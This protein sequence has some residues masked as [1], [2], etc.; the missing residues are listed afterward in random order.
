M[1]F[2]LITKALKRVSTPE[3]A[4]FYPT[5]FKT[6]P[7]EYGEGDVFIGVSVPDIRAVA[8]KFLDTPYPEI[9]ALL[10]SEIH[11][12]RTCG[13]FILVGNFQRGGEKARH[14]I[15]R[16][17]VKHMKQVN[18]WDLVDLS[19]P[20]IVGG[21]LWESKDFTTLDTWA[22]SQNLWKRRIAI[23]STLYLIRKEHFAPTLR[24]SKLLLSDSQDLIHKAVGWMLREAGKKEFAVV[25]TFVDQHGPDMPRTMLRYAIERFPKE[26][27][28]H[29]LKKTRNSP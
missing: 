25:Q 27:R 5:F 22:R 20:A 6:Q 29:Y 14:Q 28:L 12:H 21:M 15:F 8:K 3:K 24:I 11:E 7:G 26:M 2:L 13:L 19:A 18:N 10:Y 16:F 1:N 9:E 23:V 4:K 17:Y